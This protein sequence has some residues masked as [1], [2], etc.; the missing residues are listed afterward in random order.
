MS[1]AFLW[2]WLAVVASAY[3]ADVAWL[4]TYALRVFVDEQR[5]RADQE[6]EEPDMRAYL[7]PPDAL[8][9][10]N[11]ALADRFA[12]A[13]VGSGDRSAIPESVWWANVWSG[14]VVARVGRTRIEA[15]P[16][17]LIRPVGDGLLLVATHDPPDAEHPAALDAIAAILER[18]NLSSI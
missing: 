4:D 10:Q 16:W 7:S 18:L 13:V 1:S 15:V 3:G 17:H 11:S 5:R 6:A 2:Q 14:H 9:R 12:R 8:I